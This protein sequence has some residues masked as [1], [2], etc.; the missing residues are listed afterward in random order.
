MDQNEN[1]NLK[2]KIRQSNVGINEIKPQLEK[3]R[4]DARQ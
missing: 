3:L 1:T 4:S 2:E